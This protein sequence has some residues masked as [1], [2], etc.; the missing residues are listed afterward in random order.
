MAIVCLYSCLQPLL[1]HLNSFWI[2][3]VVIFISNALSGMSVSRVYASFALCMFFDI[4]V[5]CL[6]HLC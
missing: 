5:N 6:T 1:Y 3:Q 2:L 4:A